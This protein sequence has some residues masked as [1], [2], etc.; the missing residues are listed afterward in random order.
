MKAISHLTILLLFL[1]NTLLMA[2][3]AQF[4]QP[5]LSPLQFNPAMTGYMQGKQRINFQHRAQWW[6]VAGRDA[7][8]TTSISYDQRFCS[9]Y[10]IAGGIQF[11]ADKPFGNPM[12]NYQLQLSAAFHNKIGDLDQRSANDG[13]FMGFG[14]QLGGL[15]YFLDDDRLYFEDQFDPVTSGFG[16]GRSQESFERYSITALDLN[17]GVLLY[18]TKKDFNYTLGF[19]IHHINTPRVMFLDNPLLDEE[20]QEL[21]IK[22]TGYARVRFGFDNRTRF[23]LEPSAFFQ[24]QAKQWQCTG[25]L[26][27]ARE[28]VRNSSSV[29]G[30]VFYRLAS[31]WDNFT[32]FDAIIAQVGFD[33]KKI[34]LMFSYE[35]NV[36]SLSAA[37]KYVGG[38]EVGVT[39]QFGESSDCP[40]CPKFGGGNDVN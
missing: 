36:S 37:S 12:S 7:F 31:H 14:L 27:F 35:F 26:L 8:Q 40:N 30:G 19:S 22:W 20:Q 16:G 1:F 32:T 17:V 39:Y 9:E 28:L 18:S 5:L 3:D 25:G 29:T 4:A 2:Q 10:T 21:P 13:L 38:L 23:M 34:G 6:E 11:T 15:G 33:T 24:Q